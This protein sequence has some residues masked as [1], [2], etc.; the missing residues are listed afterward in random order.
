MAVFFYIAFQA[1][2]FKCLY[3]GCDKGG[4]R[5]IFPDEENAG[6]RRSLLEYRQISKIDNLRN[7]LSLQPLSEWLSIISPHPLVCNYVAENP[8]ILEQ[9]NTFLNEVSIEVCHPMI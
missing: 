2:K 5:F 9:R 1:F 7:T 4:W 8:F 6:I 3:L